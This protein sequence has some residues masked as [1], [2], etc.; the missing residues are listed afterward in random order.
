[1]VSPPSGTC[2]GLWVLGVLA[3]VAVGVAAWAVTMRGAPS[4]VKTTQLPSEPAAT[5]ITAVT[6][7]LEGILMVTRVLRAIRSDLWQKETRRRFRT[8]GAQFLGS[9]DLVK[10]ACSLL[11]VRLL[12]QGQF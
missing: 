12:S 4:E 5:T 8:T 6:A 10:N 11:F 3:A 7:R 9:Q 2:Y 1:M